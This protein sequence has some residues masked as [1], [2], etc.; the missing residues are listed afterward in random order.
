MSNYCGCKRLQHS[1]IINFT[2]YTVRKTNELVIKIPLTFVI[3]QHDNY[4]G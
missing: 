3:C 2:S 4:L 1:D